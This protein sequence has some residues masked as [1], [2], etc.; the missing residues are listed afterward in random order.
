MCRQKRDFTAFLRSR[1]TFGT[2]MTRSVVLCDC[3]AGENLSDGC[4]ATGFPTSVVRPSL[5][6]P[7]LLFAASSLPHPYHRHHHEQQ[8]QQQ[9]PPPPPD[10]EFRR[11]SRTNFT[12]FQLDALERAFSRR[13]YPD[14]GEVAELSY[15]LSI[16]E[17]RVQVTHELTGISFLERRPIARAPQLPG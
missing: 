8:R 1:R 17:S 6:H 3:L 10:L 12:G 9:P 14:S 5:N 15:Q 11:R 2:T 4:G 16:S 7:R 13:H